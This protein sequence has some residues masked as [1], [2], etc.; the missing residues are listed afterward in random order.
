MGRTVHTNFVRY[1][2]HQPGLCAY[3]KWRERSSD[4]EAW[5][6]RVG[7]GKCRMVDETGGLLV[8]RMRFGGFVQAPEYER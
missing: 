4:R 7:G 8:K 1:R 2:V 3:A 6:G 5:W